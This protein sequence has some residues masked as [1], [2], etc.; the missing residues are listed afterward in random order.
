MPTLQRTWTSVQ[1]QVPS[2]QTTQE[3]QGSSVLFALKTAFTAA[4]WTVTR[5]SNSVTA[6]TNDNWSTSADVVYGSSGAHS[7]VCLES[8]ANYASTGYRLYVAIDWIASNP[9]QCDFY[10]STADWATGTTSAIG[11]NSGNTNTWSDGYFI[12]NSLA[13][14]KFHYSTSDVGDVVF[15]VSQDSNGRVGF[16]SIINKLSNA[17]P[18]DNYPVFEYFN[19]NSNNFSSSTRYAFAFLGVQNMTSYSLTPGHWIDGTT[20]SSQ[21]AYSVD[22]TL[23][24]IL[25]G[26]ATATGDDISGKKAAVPIWVT[27]AA[28]GKYALRG[29]LTDIFQGNG[30]SIYN[31]PGNVEPAS[32]SIN[33]V[34]AGSGWVPGNVAPTF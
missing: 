13:D 24:G 18:S 28:S 15:Y 2:D 33:S 34:V 30:T 12:P 26:Q 5:S 9:D 1:N 31:L 10:V 19:T 17:D 29:T 21:R 3:K 25:N 11:S 16:G 6:D 32:G 23:I 4:G 7:W 8:P 20:I 22:N 14:V 27:T